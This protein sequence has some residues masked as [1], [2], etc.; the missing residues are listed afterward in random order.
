MHSDVPDPQSRGDYLDINQPSDY[1]TYHDPDGS[2]TLSV[3]VVHALA[4]V[5]GTDVSDVEFSLYEHIDPRA[6]DRLFAGD[7]D[8][9]PGHVAFGVEGYRVTV[10]SDG[11]IVVTPP[12]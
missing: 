1:R 2:S 11:A 6:L 8:G 9:A 12:G 7:R 4:D 10:Y 5:M 3:A